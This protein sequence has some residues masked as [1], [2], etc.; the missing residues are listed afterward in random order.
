MQSLRQDSRS[1]SQD[2][3]PM[4]AE[5]EESANHSAA[6]IGY[7]PIYVWEAYLLLSESVKI[8]TYNIIFHL[9]F[10]TSLKLGFSVRRK[11]T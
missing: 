11:N 6:M 7:R 5:C 2:S 3:E 4:S 9:L 1:P 10:C 8:K